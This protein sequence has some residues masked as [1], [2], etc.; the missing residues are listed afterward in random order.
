MKK[1]FLIGA[2]PGD[3][4][5]ITIKAVKI[6]NS[7]TVVLVDDLVNPKILEFCSQAR[8]IEVGKRGGCLSTSQKFINQL[9]VSEAI[10]GEVVVRLKGGDSFIFGRGGEEIEFLRKKD[11]TVEVIPGIPSAIGIAAK[12]QIP[13]T[14][15]LMAQGVTFVTGHTLKDNSIDWLALVKSK[16]TLVIFMGL[17]NISKIQSSL[18]KAGLPISTPAAIVQNGTRSDDFF[19]EGYI[20]DLVRL[21]NDIKQ[22]GPAIIFVGDVVSLN[23]HQTIKNPMRLQGAL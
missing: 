6:L 11:I 8:I 12:H 14:H 2:G 7:A 5:L 10:K 18:I 22:N 4:D 23:F 13:L 3:K 19:V 21:S 9:M 20:S 15:R 1:I 16:T 17:K